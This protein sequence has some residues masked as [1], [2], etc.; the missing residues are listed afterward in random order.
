MTVCTLDQDGSAVDQKLSTFNSYV[1][2]SDLKFSAF[3][4]T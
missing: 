3:G 2:E 4:D 1:T